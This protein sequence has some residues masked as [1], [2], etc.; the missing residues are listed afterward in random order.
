MPARQ[1]PSQTTGGSS[2]QPNRSKSTG[3]PRPHFARSSPREPCIPHQGLGFPPF[4]SAATTSNFDVKFHVPL[5]GPTSTQR[6]TL[7]T[8]SYPSPPV[9]VSRGPRV[10]RCDAARLGVSG[11][12][13]PERQNDDDPDDPPVC[14]PRIVTPTRSPGRRRQ[15][16]RALSAQCSRNCEDLRAAQQQLSGGLPGHLCDTGASATHSLFYLAFELDCSW[17]ARLSNAIGS[18]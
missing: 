18:M 4:Q 16:E 7:S 3:T 10:L 6:T 8:I 2:H 13:R 14:A 11:S 5:Q 9:P 15:D 12:S 17:S 1:F